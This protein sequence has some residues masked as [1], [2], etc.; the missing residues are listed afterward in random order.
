[1][2]NFK[3]EAGEGIL[4]QTVAAGRHDGVKTT[5]IDE[6][7]LTNKNIVYVYEKPK[8]LFSKPETI[9]DKIPLTLVSVV[10]GVAQVEQVR[11]ADY[12][13]TLQ[14]VY[15][16][17]T[18][19]LVE[20]SVSPE[21]NYPIWQ[22]AISDAVLAAR[23]G[24][25]FAQNYM[26]NGTSLG[27]LYKENNSNSAVGFFAESEDVGDVFEQPLGEVCQETL[28]E[29]KTMHDQ[30]N[31]VCFTEIPDDK[32]ETAECSNKSL[33]CSVC[34]TQL[35]IGAFYCHECGT[36]VKSMF[37]NSPIQKTEE[38]ESQ[39]EGQQEHDDTISLEGG[40]EQNDKN[41]DE[42]LQEKKT[43]EKKMGDDETLGDILESFSE[44]QIAAL[45]YIVRLAVKNYVNETKNERNI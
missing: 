18:R 33:F 27:Q 16:N 15:T 8:G 6:L 2:I 20:I 45:E 26:Q 9:I 38:L 35:E 22:N 40:V 24:G 25:E 5:Y 17:G 37:E 28:D 23:K 13:K 41:L 19:E 42:V 32:K 29:L 21:K 12:G 10:K 1:M 14:I 43:D 36:P 3:L 31:S 11:A 44:K 30:A 4:L 39:N 7:Y 34:K